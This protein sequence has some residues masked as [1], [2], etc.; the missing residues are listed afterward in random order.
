MS[1]E[2]Q[3]HESRRDVAVSEMSPVQSVRYVTGPY[4]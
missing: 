3:V 1:D 4:Q 2:D